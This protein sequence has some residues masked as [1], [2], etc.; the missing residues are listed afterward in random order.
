MTRN[1]RCV[2]PPFMGQA[3]PSRATGANSADSKAAE[4][5]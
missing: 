5:R 3:L 4:I 1:A 2:Q